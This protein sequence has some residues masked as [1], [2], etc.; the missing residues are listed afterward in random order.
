MNIRTRSLASTALIV[1]LG[2]GAMSAQSPLRTD[3]T[4]ILGLESWTK[5]R[6]AKDAL[7]HCKG[8]W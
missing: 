8:R 5:E 3:K 6:F 2:C 4:E 1:A 7:E